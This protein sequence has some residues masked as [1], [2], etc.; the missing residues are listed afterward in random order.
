MQP[1]SLFVQS[2][3]GGSFEASKGGTILVLRHVSTITTTFA[4]RPERTSGAILTSQFAGSFKHLVGADPP[5]AAV[6]SI[7]HGRGEFTVELSKPRYNAATR[8]LTYTARAIGSDGSDL[9]RRFGPVSIFIDAF[10]TAVNSGGPEPTNMRGRVIDRCG[11]AVQGAQMQVMAR[12]D[13]PSGQEGHLGTATTTLNGEYE[14]DNV[15]DSSVTVWITA[16]Y[17]DTLTQDVD[18]T[19]EEMN[20][21]NFTMTLVSEDCSGEPGGP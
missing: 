17:F 15:D 13:S 1:G 21:E 11:N 5:N 18:L 9:P 14:V 16:Q 6:S 20:Q 3:E 8:T 10:P 4:E 2:A 7:V 12:G 19:F